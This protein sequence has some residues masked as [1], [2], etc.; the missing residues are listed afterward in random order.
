MRKGLDSY[1]F[2][3]RY[4]VYRRFKDEPGFTLRATDLLPPPKPTDLDRETLG[5]TFCLCPS[6]TGWGMRAFHA[7]RPP[8]SPCASRLELGRQTAQCPTA[9]GDGRS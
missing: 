9:T 3:V 8:A 6:G 1:S 4:Q 5:S 2:N 7:V